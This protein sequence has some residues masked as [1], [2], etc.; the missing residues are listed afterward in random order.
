MLIS[1]VNKNKVWSLLNIIGHN[2][3]AH[4][5]ALNDQL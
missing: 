3:A 5:A 1:I 4:V 2:T